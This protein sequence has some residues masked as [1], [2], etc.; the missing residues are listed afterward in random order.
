MKDLIGLMVAII[1]IS[2]L[3]SGCESDEPKEALPSV[4]ERVFVPIEKEVT[5]TKSI[6]QKQR[7]ELKKIQTFKDPDAY[8]KVRNI[9]TLVDNDTGKEYIGISGI[10]IVEQG[11]HV[12]SKNNVPD[13]R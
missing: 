12:S 7:F 6:H 8:G 9:Y 3:F 13:E 11:T 2:I 5:I 1:S 10:G 4:G